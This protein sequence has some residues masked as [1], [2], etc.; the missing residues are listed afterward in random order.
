MHRLHLHRPSHGTVVA[1]AA[2]V[3]AMTGSAAAVGTSL[4]AK[5]SKPA[6]PVVLVKQNAVAHT[7]SASPNWA[8]VHGMTGTFKVPKS[9]HRPTL[10]TYSAECAVT[11]NPGDWAAIRIQVDGHDVTPNKSA[12]PGS[13]NWDGDFAFC[14]PQTSGATTDAGWI[15]ASV[16]GYKKLSPG[17]HHVK[18]QTLLD[19]ATAVRLDDMQLSVVAEP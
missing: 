8:T 9:A 13:D 11:G 10:F 4:H 18:V 3:L 7:Y 17:T 2:L 1:Y 16:Q 15:G 19:T 6:K 14:S 12:T 5:H